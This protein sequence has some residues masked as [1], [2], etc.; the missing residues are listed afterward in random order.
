M[1]TLRGGTD[2]EDLALGSRYAV[3]H[4]EKKERERTSSLSRY[5]ALVSYTKFFAEAAGLALY[6]PQG[7]TGF[8]TPM[9]P[10]IRFYR[11][12]LSVT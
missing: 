8:E 6:K 4:R 5:K 3:P 9:R 12:P 1:Y 7:E 10:S 11:M 2:F